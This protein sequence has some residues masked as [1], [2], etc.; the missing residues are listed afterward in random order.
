M[1]KRHK[2]ACQRNIYLGCGLLIINIFSELV[3]STQVESYYIQSSFI[4]TIQ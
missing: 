3:T 4:D 2:N 1:G